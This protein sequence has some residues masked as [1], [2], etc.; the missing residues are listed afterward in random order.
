MAVDP[1]K[2]PKLDF[3][4]LDRIVDEDRRAERRR[5]RNVRFTRADWMAGGCIAVVAVAAVVWLAQG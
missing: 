1:D 4:H 3:G 5:G 2:L